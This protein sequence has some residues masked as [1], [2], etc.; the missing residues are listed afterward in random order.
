M[1]IEDPAL[2]GLPPLADEGFG[3]L[4]PL[5]DEGFG[6]LPPPADEALCGLP[7]LADEGFGGLP[8]LAD[9][10]FD[11][12]WE[13]VRSELEAEEDERARAAEAAAAEDVKYLV[14]AGVAVRDMTLE[15]IRRRAQDV[16][17]RRRAAARRTRVRKAAFVEGLEA[18]NRRLRAENEALK[19]WLESAKAA[20]A[21]PLPG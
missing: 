11:G 20:R 16:R 9:E 18:E 17:D 5:A 12:L 15:Q 4:P 14:A 13:F 8:P 1:D 21:K 19:R 7:P 6:G 10:A 2:G 3:G